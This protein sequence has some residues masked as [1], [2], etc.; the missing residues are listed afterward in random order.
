VIQGV[1]RMDKGTGEVR[2]RKAV[3]SMLGLGGGGS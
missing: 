1:P 3:P 2:R